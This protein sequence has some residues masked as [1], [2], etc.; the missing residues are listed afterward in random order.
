[1]KLSKS[2]W[3]KA[4]LNLFCRFFILRTTNHERY[5]R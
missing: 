5:A 1:L 3:R 2:G 4:R